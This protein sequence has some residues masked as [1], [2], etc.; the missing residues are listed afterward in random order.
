[1]TQEHLQAL[2]AAA[3]AKKTEQGW[4]ALPDGRAV[5]L[6]VAA[7]GATLTISRVRALKLEGPL[8]HAETHKG[9]HYVVALE[10]A[11][12]GSVEAPAAATKK[13][14]FL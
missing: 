9:E 7:D 11:Y 8:V 13:A 10:D 14:G 6:Y 12:A 4:M 2:F 3:Q 1:M 5:T